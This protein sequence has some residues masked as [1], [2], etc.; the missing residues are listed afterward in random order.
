MNAI[1]P[2]LI[3]STIVSYNEKQFVKYFVNMHPKG[4]TVW[5]SITRLSNKDKN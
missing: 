5:Q 3:L 2:A 4:P 1:N